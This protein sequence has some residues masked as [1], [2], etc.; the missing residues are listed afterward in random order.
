MASQTFIH[1][2]VYNVYYTAVH[3]YNVYYTVVHVYNV[4]Y[5]VV[6]VL[7]VQIRGPLQHIFTVLC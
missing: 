2:H 7:H 4:Y 6:H 5:T 3:V 1:I